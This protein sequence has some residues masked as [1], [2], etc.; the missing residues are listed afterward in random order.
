MIAV[1]DENRNTVLNDNGDILIYQTEENGDIATDNSGA[2]ITAASIFPERLVE[3]KYIQTPTYTLTMPSGWSVVE[4][5]YN[6]FKKKSADAT[7]TVEIVEGYALDDYIEYMESVIE[8]LVS[9]SDK[10]EEN[11]YEGKDTYEYLAA[12][13]TATRFTLAQKDA[14]GK[15]YK[16]EAV[17]FEKNGNLYK[18]I[19]EAPK[20][21]FEKANFA[22]FFSAI[23]YKNYKYY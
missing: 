14:D 11:R 4:D 10:G 1:T 3:G 20:K 5:K 9:Q 12:K 21:S 13:A 23:N 18:F 2:P 19:C 16:W 7:I 22:E 6:A 17:V 15:E 8:V